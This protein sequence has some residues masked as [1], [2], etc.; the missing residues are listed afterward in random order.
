MG[1]ALQLVT[2]SAIRTYVGVSEEVSW[3]RHGPIREMLVL[4][5]EVMSH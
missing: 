4:I 5:I 1:V 3:T 2:Q